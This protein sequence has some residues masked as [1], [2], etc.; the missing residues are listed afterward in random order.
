MIHPVLPATAKGKGSHGLLV[1]INIF[2]IIPPFAENGPEQ[3][4]IFPVGGNETY[5]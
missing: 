1:E 5:P 3:I 2:A 4:D